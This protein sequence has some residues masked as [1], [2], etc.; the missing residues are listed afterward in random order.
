MTG[1]KA[2]AFAFYQEFDKP[3]HVNDMS[4]VSG[5][6]FDIN[7]NWQTPHSMHRDGRNADLNRSTMSDTKRTYFQQ[8]A[9]ALGFTVEVHPSGEGKPY[10]WH[11]TK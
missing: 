6:L 11:L 3:L 4:L 5:G 10:H 9:Q 7:D 1:C 2:L 8:K